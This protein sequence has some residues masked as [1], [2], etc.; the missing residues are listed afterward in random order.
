M[1]DTLIYRLTKRAEIRSSITSRK[2]VQENLPDRISEL[3][4][5]AASRI[6]ELESIV[7]GYTVL[8]DHLI[9]TT[10]G[11]KEDYDN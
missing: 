7:Q 9:K 11:L 6:E 2:S 5:E 10:D 1:N 8:T 4:L 3:L